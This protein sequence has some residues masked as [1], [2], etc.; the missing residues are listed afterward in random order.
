MDFARDQNA[1]LIMVWK[2]IRPRWRD[3]IFG[4]LADE[5]TNSGEID[6]YTV[7]SEVEK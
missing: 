3:F 2:H 7:T 1:T 5:L 6:I 4:S